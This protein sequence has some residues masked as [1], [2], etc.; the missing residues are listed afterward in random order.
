M[1]DAITAN[2]IR[3]A[4]DLEGLDLE[5]L[6]E[7]LTED[8]A[9]IASFRLLIAEQEEVDIDEINDI[10]NNLRALAN[11]YETYTTALSDSEHRISAAFV[12]A[13]AHK[14]LLQIGKIAKINQ[15]AQERLSINGIS[16]D[17][18]ASLL[19]LIADYHADAFEISQYFVDHEGEEISDQLIRHLA[20]MS[21]GKLIDILEDDLFNDFQLNYSFLDNPLYELEQKSCDQLWYYILWALRGYA[22]LILNVDSDEYSYPGNPNEI[23]DTVLDLCSIELVTTNDLNKYLG[24]DLPILISTYAGPHH[25]AS[26]LKSAGDTLIHRAVTRVPPPDGID[27]NKWHGFT[28][29]YAKH[30]P[31]LWRNHWDAVDKDYLSPNSSSVITIPTG[32]GKTTLAELK[33]GSFLIE[34]KSIIYLAPTHALVDQTFNRLKKLFGERFSIN[35]SLDISISSDISDLDLPCIVVMTP[36]R[37]LSQMSINP[38]C[39]DAF[40]LLVFDEFHMIHPTRG[41]NDKRSIDAMFC[42]LL[43]ISRIPDMKLLMMSAMISNTHELAEWISMTT[44]Q[45]CIPIDVE[46]KPTRQARGCLVYPSAQINKL[47]NILYGNRKQKRTKHPNKNIKNTLKAVPYTLFCLKQSWST[48]D[49]NDYHLIQLLKNAVV[50]S[51][52]K[53]WLLTPNRNKVACNIANTLSRANIKTL[54]FIQNKQQCISSAKD[55]SNKLPESQTTSLTQEESTLK[56]IAIDELGDSKFIACLH[57]NKVG[58]HNALLLQS[59]RLLVESVYSRSDG[60]NT[61]IATPTLAQGINLPAEF[62][63][64][65]GDDRFDQSVNNQQG[66]MKQLEAHELL[67]AAGRAGRAGKFASG[68]VLVIPGQV[69]EFNEEESTISRRWFDL[70]ERIFSKSDQCI[71]MLDPIDL[72]LDTIQDQDELDYSSMYFINRTPDFQEDKIQQFFKNSLSAF[73]AK[74]NDTIEN[75]NYRV[76]TVVEIKKSL[77]ENNEEDESNLRLSSAHGIP[78]EIIYSIK[79]QLN[80]VIPD[81]PLKSAI[82]FYR[83]IFKNDDYFFMFPKLKDANKL[84][85]DK[86]NKYPKLLLTATKMWLDAYPIIDIEKLMMGNDKHSP[87]CFNAR[88]F[89]LDVIPEVSHGINIIVDIYRDLISNNDELLIPIGFSVAS[90]CIRDGHNIPEKLAIRFLSNGIVSRKNCHDEYE[91]ISANLGEANEYE[92]FDET[93][94]RVKKAMELSNSEMQENL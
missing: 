13:T 78:Q 87:F 27:N 31:Y 44:G 9:K 60:I 82:W 77:F 93:I 34:N 41:L 40:E 89:V 65:A 24:K 28:K 7:L 48:Q 63:I 11:T 86:S 67:N 39:L 4:P 62:V 92:S 6:P 21:R 53:R 47:Q 66:G 3:N 5:R 85:K 36:E 25:L 57:K 45:R 33:I 69:V 80:K 52:N 29:L 72:Y 64:I 58:S 12:A 75:F 20:N 42:L 19:F 70:Q 59:E 37:C 61:L 91:R 83:W 16:S 73:F 79:T 71:E 74:K 54:I 55:L 56:N 18:S 23:L 84:F 38:D 51:A 43:I 49:S 26:L 81:T 2:L 30:Y 94:K 68:V 76:G 88:K 22:G 46:W 17:I 10:I 35:R 1:F 15:P 32:G 90:S 50:L 14:L 8:Y